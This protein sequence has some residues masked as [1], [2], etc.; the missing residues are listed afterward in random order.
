[1]QLSTKVLY[2]CQTRVA[3]FKDTRF[4]SRTEQQY[5]NA[6]KTVHDT[7]L[8]RYSLPHRMVPVNECPT[9]EH[10]GGLTQDPVEHPPYARGA[11]H[12]DIQVRCL[13]FGARLVCVV[14][15]AF[16]C[17]DFNQSTGD[18]RRMSIPELV[19]DKR[20]LNHIS[21]DVQ[22]DKRSVGRFL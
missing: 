12:C 11:P 9:A 14:R 3:I 21:T 1:M 18:E 6:W 7:Q 5:I 22:K 16:I 4:D 20:V 17:F 19:C 2:P 15:R 8:P 10:L 13:R